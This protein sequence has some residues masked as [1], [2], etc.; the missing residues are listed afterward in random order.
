MCVFGHEGQ[1]PGCG[2]RRQVKKAAKRG[3]VGAG[4]F[5]R[6]SRGVALAGKRT[7]DALAGV[8]H[9]IRLGLAAGVAA[10][11]TEA[12]SLQELSELPGLSVRQ[13]TVISTVCS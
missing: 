7:A 9:V 8:D 12:S 10:I 5:G 11:I 13:M 1:C 6:L 4:P 2:Q 3:P